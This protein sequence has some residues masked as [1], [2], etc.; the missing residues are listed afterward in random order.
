[1]NSDTKYEVKVALGKLV[2]VPDKY[3][4]M[5]FPV[6]TIR[7]SFTVNNLAIKAFDDQDLKWQYLS[8][9]VHTA[10]VASDK[11]VESLVKVTL[12][13]HSLPL[14]WEHS[15]DGRNHTFTTDSLERT[16][17]TQELTVSWN[18][19]PLDVNSEGEQKVELPALDQFKVTEVRVVQQPQQYL[20]L[21][22]SDPLDK[23]QNLEGLVTIDKSSKNLRFL[24]DNNTLQVFT[25]SPLTGEHQIYISEGI[26]NALGYKL[27]KSSGMAVRFED[28]K[29]AV[30][31]I[32]KGTIMLH[33]TD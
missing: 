8:G 30:K 2:D 3:K 23:E 18:G 4:V 1:M 32:G 14:I 28:L 13:N 25:P 31:F 17:A 22:F 20:V 12:N 21:R 5:K 26:R 19:K 16:N 10:D 15:G 11:N 24:V 9:M 29:P 33:P 7:Q 6:K 27:G